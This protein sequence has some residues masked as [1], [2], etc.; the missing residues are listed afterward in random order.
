LVPHH[1]AHFPQF[2]VSLPPQFNSQ[3]IEPKHKQPTVVPWFQNP[4]FS[5][6]EKIKSF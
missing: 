1:R 6:F 3:F 2:F 5:I 4:N